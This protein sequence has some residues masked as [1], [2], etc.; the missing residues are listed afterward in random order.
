MDILK[1]VSHLLAYPTAELIAHRGELAEVVKNAEQIPPTMRQSLIDM[2]EE[3]AGRDLMDIQEEYGSLFDRGRSLSLLLFE[4]VHGESRDRGQAMVDLMANYQ[5]AGFEISVRE[6]PDYIPLYLEYLAQ[7]PEIDARMGLAD[8][9][10]ILGML[11]ARLQERNSLY[12]LL[13]DTLLIISGANV[14][15][16][17]LRKTAAAEE[18]DDTMEALDEVWEEEAVR[19]GSEDNS[20]SC[21]PQSNLGA[22]AAQKARQEQAT[23]MHWVDTN[24]QTPPVR[25]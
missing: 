8:V 21:Q 13:F 5:Q 7:Q 25:H 15:V 11:S 18:R 1:V 16:E 4:H 14:D 9:A 22:V 17:E 10:H 19:F 2:M 23:P 24:Q 3:L 12:H 20:A 6:L